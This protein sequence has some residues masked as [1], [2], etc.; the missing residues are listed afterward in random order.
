MGLKD[1]LERLGY[2]LKLCFTSVGRTRNGREYARRLLARPRFEEVDKT[3]AIRMAT[4][5]SP[6]FLPK[7]PKGGESGVIKC[8]AIKRGAH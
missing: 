7:N 2:E 5:N 3:F 8:I 6:D 1:L 4:L